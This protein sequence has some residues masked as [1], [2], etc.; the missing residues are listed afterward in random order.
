MKIGDPCEVLYLGQWVPGTIKHMQTPTYESAGSR[1]QET[2]K[3]G[4]VVI[5]GI[6]TE[7][8][9]VQGVAIQY[10]T[11]RLP[12]GRKEGMTDA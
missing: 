6:E 9:Y 4:P 12:Q 10:G 2:G 1:V 11:M 3:S 5:C 8:A 7:K